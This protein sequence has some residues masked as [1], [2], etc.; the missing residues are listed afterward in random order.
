MPAAELLAAAMRGKLLLARIRH[1]QGQMHGL[2]FLPV[3]FFILRMHALNE[4]GT[5][6]ASTEPGYLIVKACMHHDDYL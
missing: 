4:E 1:P 2:L 3:C 6:L 5:A